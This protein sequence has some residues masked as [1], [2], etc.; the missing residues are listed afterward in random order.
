ME[1][2]LINHLKQKWVHKQKNKSAKEREV[3]GFDKIK[4]IGV[5]YPVLDTHNS[6]LRIIED[7]GNQN[8]I[9]ILSL[10]YLNS[11]NMAESMNP[12]HKTDFFCNKDLNW[13]KLPNVSDFHRFCNNQFDCLFNMYLTPIHPLMALSNYSE[14][15]FR[16]GGMVQ[17]VY[18]FDVVIDYN[19]TD[20]KT[21][22]DLFINQLR[23]FK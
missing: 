1:H 4:Q 15:R 16:V 20:V 23:K 7:F 6:A 21:Y 3:V 18:G 5:L 19:G 8:N 11:K 12:N 2:K 10:G 13:L 9:S 17:D 14:A 22:T